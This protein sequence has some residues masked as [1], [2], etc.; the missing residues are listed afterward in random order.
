M[1]NGE[2]TF[3]PVK[4]TDQPLHS[5]P[6]IAK[7]LDQNLKR[8][9]E[10]GST[11]EMAQ[12]LTVPQMPTQ[13]PV[14]AQFAPIQPQYI[15]NGSKAEL[16]SGPQLAFGTNEDLNSL[17]AGIKEKDI[18]VY[19]EVQLPSFG[20]FYDGTE[21]TK[22]G[23][24]HVRPMAGTEEQILSN[25]AFYKGAQGINKIFKSCVQENIVPERMLTVDRNA[26]LVYIR[27]IS[28]GSNYDVEV[29]CPNCQNHFPETINLNRDVNACPEDLTREN[30]KETLPVTGYEFTYRFQ[31]NADEIAVSKYVEK[32]SKVRNQGD[33]FQGDDT[34]HHRASIL[35]TCIE[36]PTTKVKITDQ[37]SIKMLLQRLPIA[38]TSYIRETLL[39]QPFGMDMKT[40]IECPSC[41]YRWDVEMPLESSFFFPNT[42]KKRIQQNTR[43]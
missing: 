15:Q 39:D 12:G 16:V 8:M 3:R 42:R 17:L 7:A 26:L 19:R 24:I 32:K 23:V 13:Q 10:E 37:G 6:F 38:D 29:N 43:V 35:I 2:N 21:C 40:E 34:F 9:S 28:F 4:K 22:N 25:L 36:D 31:T 14:Q 5:N 41:Q 27:A 30:L 33:N 11:E 1:Q 20:K 18:Y